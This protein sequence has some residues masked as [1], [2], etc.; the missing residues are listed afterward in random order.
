VKTSN[1][2]EQRGGVGTRCQ[3]TLRRSRRGAQEENL[4]IWRSHFY[5]S[6]N[7]LQTRQQNR[8]ASASSAKQLL[9]PC[10][11]VLGVRPIASLLRCHNHPLHHLTGRHAISIMMSVITFKSNRFSSVSDLCAST[12][13]PVPS[14]RM[15]TAATSLPRRTITCKRSAPLVSEISGST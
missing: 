3:Q 2:R 13:R 8:R 5:R 10:T 4:E 1:L 6:G 11:C 14:D 15:D 7:T 9:Q 12:R